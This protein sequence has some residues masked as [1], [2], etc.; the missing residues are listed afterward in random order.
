MR[1]EGVRDDFIHVLIAD[2]TRIHTELLAAALQRDV[3][4]QTVLAGPKV[5]DVVRA[6]SQHAFD[7][8]IISSSLA[9]E[10]FGGLELLRTLRD[11]HPRLRLI[12]LLDSD[13]PEMI[14]E[15]FRAGARGILCREESLETLSKCVHRVY[16]GQVWAS[17]REITKVLDAFSACP[18]VRAVDA[19]GVEL[20]SKREKQIVNALAEGL[21]NKEIAEHLGLSPHTVKNYLFRIFDKVG[22][23]SRV[24]L[25]SLTMNGHSTNVEDS[26]PNQKKCSICR[27]GVLLWLQSAANDGFVVAQRTLAHLYRVGQGV[28]RDLSL[29]YKWHLISEAACAGLPDELLT[30]RKE[31]H[32]MLSPDELERAQRLAKHWLDRPHTGELKD[33]LQ[34]FQDLQQ[35][36]DQRRGARRQPT[37]QPEFLSAD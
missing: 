30:A 5:D 4:L 2:S 22:V 21:T 15:A 23:S 1:T 34:S 31:L 27:S 3:R 13:K 26:A 35:L 25:L 32:R 24:E 6:S 28:P 19:K 17:S 18:S 16:E 9:N 20:L 33:G 12:A 7:V 14:V 8:A 10:P 37:E 36:E 29:A 11:T